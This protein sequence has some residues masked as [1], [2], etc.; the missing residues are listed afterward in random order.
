M[1][2]VAA[3]GAGFGA[4]VLWDLTVISVLRLFDIRLPFSIAIR[5][6]PRRQRE[7]FTALKGRGKGTFVFISGFLLSTCPVLS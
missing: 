7:L 6:Y 5:F 4:I 2:W 1:L 3:F